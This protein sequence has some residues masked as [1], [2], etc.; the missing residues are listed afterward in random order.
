MAR[1][2]LLTDEVALKVWDDALLRL[3]DYTPFQTYAWGEYRRALGWKPCRWAAFNER[4][5]IVAMMLGL[6]RRYPLKFGLI[7]SE[8]GPVGDL[9]TCDATLQNAI[10][11]TTR[12][13]RVYCRFRC[14]RERSIE[15]A[16]TLDTHGWSRSWFTLTPNFSM[17]LDLAKEESDLLAACDRKWRRNLRLANAG[18]L[19]VRQ[20]A[21]PSVDAILPVYSSMQS[22]KG[23]EEQLSRMEIAHLLSN[24]KK[25][26]VFYG[27]EN[28]QGALVSLQAWLVLADRAWMILSATSEEGRKL[29]A[30]YAVFWALVQHSLKIGVSSCDLAGID[31]IRNHGV[32]RFKRSTGARPLEYL[33]E[34]DW[35]TSP[36][37]LWCGNWA[38]RNREKLRRTE[39]SAKSIAMVGEKDLTP[40]E[41]CG[42]RL[43]QPN[44]AERLQI[45]A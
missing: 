19:V 10:K 33:G 24:L 2:E 15:D 30:S 45:S 42:E 22:L 7:W 39:S 6:L 41:T 1:W 3:H 32:Y 13:K 18:N 5:E 16:L 31:P 29:N 27:C 12:L 20:Y 36:W 8:G 34:W 11:E 37:L 38:I 40:K 17:Y 28:E 43:P 35:A 23:L 9:S 26:I 21:N 25:N 4:G 14:D 44:V